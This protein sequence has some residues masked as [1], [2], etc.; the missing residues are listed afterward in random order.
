[1]RKFKVGDRVQFKKRTSPFYGVRGTVVGRF[2]VEHY[3]VQLDKGSRYDTT[4]CDRQ[5]YTINQSLI[6]NG[7]D[8]TVTFR[9]ENL[10]LI[11][12]PAE[13]NHHDYSSIQN[14]GIF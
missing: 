8:P 11:N 5:G 6:G 1:M 9:G 4:H 13:P 10:V 3:R 7:R 2:K 14:F 12:K